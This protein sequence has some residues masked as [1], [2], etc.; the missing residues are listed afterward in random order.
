MSDTASVAAPAAEAPA[1][2]RLPLTAAQSGMWYAQR[3]APDSPIYNGGQY[4]EIHGPVDEALFDA[5]L[6]QVVRETDA[7]RTRFA[8]RA[9]GLWQIV[10]PDPEW[11]LRVVDLSAEDDPQAAAESWMWDD[12]ARPV[13]LLAGPLFL[14]ALVKAAPDRY[15]WYLRCH[16]IA[17]DGFSSALVAQRVAEVHSALA[18]GT[19][20][21]PNPFGP[22]AALVAE[23]TA[24]R[25]SDRFALDGAYWREHL[26]DRPEPVSLSGTQPFLPRRLTRRSAR[27]GPETAKALRAAADE[28]GVPFPP[29]V[30]AV[31]AAY[32]QSLTGGTEAVVGLPV[33]TR[34]GRTARTTPGMVSNMLPLRLSVRPGMSLRDLLV[35]VSG[36]MRRTMRHQR[37]RYEDV[38]RDLGLLGDD[39][40]LVGPHV[41]IMMFGDALRFAG[42]RSSAHTLN[43]GPVDDLSVVV[44]EQGDDGSLSIDFEANPDLY[45]GSELAGHQERFLNFADTLVRGGIDAPVGRAELMLPAE[46]RRALT[47]WTNE[48]TAAPSTT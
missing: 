32:L 35:H 1:E 15:F 46:T 34:L 38:R 43:L 6:H 17:L 39:Q 30:T 13:D 41:N 45:T 23:D 31:F 3:M 22:L 26:A 7:L 21:P 33:T 9:D 16:H 27:I 47:E 44:H 12:L 19:D 10:D 24:Y 36:E 40:R 29:V 42:H 5:A 37:Y 18:A 14:F 2:V 48:V 20:V 11:S 25:A 28:A 8:E 4:L